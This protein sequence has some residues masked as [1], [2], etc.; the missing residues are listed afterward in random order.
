MQDFYQ[1][2]RAQFA[3]SGGYFP[4]VKSADPSRVIAPA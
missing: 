1:T 2:I 3:G 4:Q